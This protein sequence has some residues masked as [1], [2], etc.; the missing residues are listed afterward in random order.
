MIPQQLPL[1]VAPLYRWVFLLGQPL[2]PDSHR[3]FPQQLAHPVSLARRWSRPFC[4]FVSPETIEDTHTN[5]LLQLAQ[6]YTYC[7]EDVSRETLFAMTFQPG[8]HLL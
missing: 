2:L 5:L 7:A 1:P 3:L 8:V 6:Q 4:L